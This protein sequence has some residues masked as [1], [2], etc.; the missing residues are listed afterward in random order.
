MA[1]A[2]GLILD[3]RVSFEPVRPGWWRMSGRGTLSG[4]FSRDVLPVGVAS[5][6]GPLSFTVHGSA[7][8]AR[9]AKGLIEIAV[10][11]AAGMSVNLLQR[12]VTHE[13]ETL[14]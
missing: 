8:R 12:G 9:R 14:D 10:L 1:G 7:L 2:P 13:V 11:T 3:G 5:P 4:L 6:A